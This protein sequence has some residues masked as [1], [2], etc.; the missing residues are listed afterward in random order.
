MGG[1]SQQGAKAG[2]QHARSTSAVQRAAGRVKNRAACLAGGGVSGTEG[3]RQRWLQLDRQGSSAR[4][5]PRLWC[6]IATLSKGVWH[7]K[8]FQ[9]QGSL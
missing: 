6:V 2:P 1:S 8:V 3:S 5:A 4:G 9:G 7:K